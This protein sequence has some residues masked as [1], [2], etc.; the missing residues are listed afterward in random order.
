MSLEFQVKLPI[1]EGHTR[2]P[3]SLQMFRN[4]FFLISKPSGKF[5]LLSL[6]GSV[7]TFRASSTFS[8]LRL[9]TQIAIFRQGFNKVG[10]GK[11]VF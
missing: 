9:T 5:L 1:I 10:F 2:E 4:H 6:L 11:E 7:Q 8:S 3:I